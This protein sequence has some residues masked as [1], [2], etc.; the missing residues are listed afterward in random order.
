MGLYWN[1]IVFFDV[2]LSPASPG[3]R[4][5]CRGEPGQGLGQWETETAN[6]VQTAAREELETQLEAEKLRGGPSEDPA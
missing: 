4:A 2:G 5:R 3:P 6:A 1:R